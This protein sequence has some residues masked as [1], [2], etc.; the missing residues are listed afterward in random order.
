MNNFRLHIEPI[1]L[2][3]L[4]QEYHFRG[5]IKIALWI[6]LDFKRYMYLVI[7]ESRDF[8]CDVKIAS[9]ISLG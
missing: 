2:A 8:R 9:W 4:G 3:Y 1:N 7:C 5:D 6:S